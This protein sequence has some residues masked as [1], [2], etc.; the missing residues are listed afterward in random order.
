MPTYPLAFPAVGVKKSTFRL[1]SNVRTA[2]S[3]FTGE[4]QVYPLSAQWWEGEIQFPPMKRSN[5]RLIQAFL[6]ELRGRYG[7]FLYGDP[8]AI[9]Q[10]VMGS[11]GTILVNGA[12]QSGNTLAVDG[13]AAGASNVLVPGDYFQLGTGS[14]ARLYMVTQPLNANG[15]GQG[16][17]TF[18]PALRAA[19]A[20]NEALI[21]SQ[22]KTV[23]RLSD[24]VAE[25]S[26]DELGIYGFTLSFREVL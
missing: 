10:G 14:A 2:E 13:M 22:P 11:G 19:P 1:K 8:D 3:P 5:A 6:A 12:A 18:E 21:L 15:S 25:W 4:V 24:D 20:D 9:Q 17:L 26:S 23:M 7:T 16:T